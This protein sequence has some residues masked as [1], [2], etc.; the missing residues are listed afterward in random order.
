MGV[1]VLETDPLDILLGPDGDIVVDPVKGLQFVSGVPGVLQLIRIRMLMFAGEW[2][3]NLNAG[4]DWWGTILGD[5][6]NERAAYDDIYNQMIQVPG[7]DSIDSL[8]LTFNPINRV[9]TIDF[10]VTCSFGDTASDTLNLTAPTG[11]PPDPNA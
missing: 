2:F 1:P 6:F 8:V 5:V 7:V 4:V 3:L 9:L 11:A 10:S